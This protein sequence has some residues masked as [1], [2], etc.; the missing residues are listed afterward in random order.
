MRLTNSVL[1]LL[2]DSDGL[3]EALP[4]F[5]T[6][7]RHNISAYSFA[8]P[9]QFR[10][11]YFSTSARLT[12]FSDCELYGDSEMVIETAKSHLSIIMT[13]RLR[14]DDYEY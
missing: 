9:P 5:L 11:S 14:W 6:A 7:L 13:R 4:I 8:S 1:P 3:G 2:P 10:S 12:L